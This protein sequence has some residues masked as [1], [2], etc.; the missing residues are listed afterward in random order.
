ML[1]TAGKQN[2]PPYL[3]TVVDEPCLSNHTDS[4]A[5]YSNR[6][7]DITDEDEEATPIYWVKVQWEWDKKEAYVACSRCSPLVEI[8]DIDE[9]DSS[10]RTRRHLRNHP[11][12]PKRLKM[13]PSG[14]KSQSYVTPDNQQSDD[15][16]DDD[17]GKMSVR[18]KFTGTLEEQQLQ[19]AQQVLYNSA[20]VRKQEADEALQL[21]GPPY[22]LQ[23]LYK[24]VQEMRESEEWKDPGLFEVKKG[25][26]VRKVSPY[27]PTRSSLILYICYLKFLCACH[28][29]L[30]GSTIVVQ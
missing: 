30:M 16:A 21:V 9:D 13:S 10:G 8:D 4:S 28:R 23:E 6:S 14:L 17:S 12:S 5:F 26:A 18:L 11:M 1:W 27:N 19:R 24:K 3:C 7:D 2:S 25:M 29:C 22:G 15:N 20:D